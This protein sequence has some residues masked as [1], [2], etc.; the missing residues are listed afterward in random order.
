MGLV[1]LK[2]SFNHMCIHEGTAD[3]RF[4]NFFPDL[5]RNCVSGTNGIYTLIEVFLIFFF[6]LDRV[7]THQIEFVTHV[8]AIGGS[9]VHGVVHSG[10]EIV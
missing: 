4:L 2:F 10:K 5:E 7:G 6:D 1:N 8:H 9:G 3:H